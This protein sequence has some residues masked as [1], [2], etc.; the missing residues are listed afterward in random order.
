MSE[1]SFER[2]ETR[3]GHTP[4]VSVVKYFHHNLQQFK[5][6]LRPY[7]DLTERGETFGWYHTYILELSF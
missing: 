7:C 3:M 6:F 5:I 4:L 2:N 1:T